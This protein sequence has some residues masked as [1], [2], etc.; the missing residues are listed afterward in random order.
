MDQIK[1]YKQHIADETAR[2][3]A[4][5]NDYTKTSSYANYL[6]NIKHIEN[7]IAK[8]T[9]ETAR[10]NAQMAEHVVANSPEAAALFRSDP[11]AYMQKYG[12]PTDIANLPQ[13][14]AVR[15]GGAT[16]YEPTPQPT[17]TIA[18]KDGIAPT[19]N[20]QTGAA[21]GYDVSQSTPVNISGNLTRGSKGEEVKRL[22]EA[23]NASGIGVNLK[24]DGDFGPATEAAVRA[25]QSSKNIKSDG[26]VGQQTIA[27][28]SGTPNAPLSP[29]YQEIEK[30]ANSDP[31]IVELEKIAGQVPE[32]KSAL[33]ALRLQISNS[34]E[35]GQVVNPSLDFNDPSIIG[36]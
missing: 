15:T 31:R 34:L 8:D 4:A 9:A 29:A 22:Q 1:Q 35:N 21:S 27:T 20:Q 6:R 7:N 13:N 3:A 11:T 24:V 12:S 14:L 33:D 18:N 5:G 16:G 36:P 28:L 26:I 2:Y 19:T 17:S 10:Y 32:L 25:Y 30:S 23:L